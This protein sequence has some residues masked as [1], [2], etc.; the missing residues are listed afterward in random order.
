M[1]R[2]KLEQNAWEFSGERSPP[3]P[4]RRATRGDGS[5]RRANGKAFITFPC[6]CQA[7]PCSEP[8]PVIGAIGFPFYSNQ[9]RK[10][11]VKY[12]LQTLALFKVERAAAKLS[13]RSRAAHNPEPDINHRS[14]QKHASVENLTEPRTRTS[15]DGRYFT[16]GGGGGG[17][18]PGHAHPLISPTNVHYLGFL[19]R[20]LA[21]ARRFLDEDACRRSAQVGGPGARLT[22]ARASRRSRRRQ[23]PKSRVHVHTYLEGI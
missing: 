5:R 23:A 22:Y 7:N 10:K 6:E 8:V 15:Q 3:A 9:V 11:F 2:V 13:G 19:R 4:A 18:R 21:T 20:A 16:R 1:A 17:P 14:L 12:S